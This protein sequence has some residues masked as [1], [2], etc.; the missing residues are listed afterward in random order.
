MSSNKNADNNK[1][2]IDNVND[3]VDAAMAMGKQRLSKYKKTTRGLMGSFQNL[4]K[5][6][7]GST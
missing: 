3:T 6:L 2:K 1:P 7:W 4:V 5:K